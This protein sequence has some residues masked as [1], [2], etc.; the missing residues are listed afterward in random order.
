AKRIHPSLYNSPHH[1]TSNHPKGHRM[2]ARF[3]VGLIAFLAFTPILHAQEKRAITIDDYFTQA[4]LFR[5]A[6]SRDLIAYAEG[7]W[8]EATDDRKTGLWVVPTKG[9]PAR[10]LTDDRPS[11]RSPIFH[12]D[13]ATIFYLANHKREGEKR[14]PYDGKAQVWRIGV[15]GKP[16]SR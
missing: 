11:A 13:G 4:D 10:R 15:E 14:P 2:R 8:Q 9:G 1:P 7:R 3:L 12:P 5:V 16:P 6:Y